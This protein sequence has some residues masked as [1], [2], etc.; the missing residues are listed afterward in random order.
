[1]R[2]CTLRLIL[3]YL[4]VPFSTF[5]QSLISAGEEPQ[6]ETL[7]RS[8]PE[9]EH[10]LLHTYLDIRFDYEKSY[11]YGKTRI[12]LSPQF[13]E[14]DSL[15]LDA[16]GMDIHKVALVKGSQLAP[17]IYRYDSLKLSIRL[18]KKYKRT[19]TYQIQIE[20]TAKPNEYKGKGSAAI[21]DAKGL[22]FINPK[23]TE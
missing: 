20:Y 23:G 6:W 5:A 15:V 17:L 19:E 7:Y 22:Y 10:T 9:K 1:M 14:S 4:L 3:T 11:A 8:T 21:T 12:T 13:Y 16:K 2:F 18:D